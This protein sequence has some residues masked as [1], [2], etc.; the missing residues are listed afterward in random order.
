MA[1]T[2]R[3][4]APAAPTSKRTGMTE[5]TVTPAMEIAATSTTKNGGPV[6]KAE[7]GFGDAPRALDARSENP[8][9]RRKRDFMGK[10]HKGPPKY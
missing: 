6:P 10:Q 8:E 2:K 9:E 3:K 1:S 7:P 4:P 5:Y